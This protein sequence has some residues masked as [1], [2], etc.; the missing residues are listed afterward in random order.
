MLLWWL[1]TYLITCL[2]GYVIHRSLHQPWAGRFNKSHLRHHNFLYP[3]E[4]YLSDTYRDP[5]SDSTVFIFIVPSLFMLAIPIVLGAVGVV[6]W[7]LAGTMVA[8]MLV[9]GWLHNYLHDAM[10]IRGHLLNRLSLFR[11]W[12]ALHKQH[13]RNQQT[14]FGIFG[15]GYDK[16]FGTYKESE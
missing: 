5:G 4:D 1:A 6:A 10:H 3:P 14:N 11:R 8:E 2:F 15:F 9:I 12:N 16:V 13:H 7:W